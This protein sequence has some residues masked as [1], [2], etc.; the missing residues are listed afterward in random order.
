MSRKFMFRATLLTALLALTI[1]PV[2]LAGKGGGKPGG[3]G[4]TGGT[5]SLSLVLLDS[6]D[7]LAHYG[8][9]VTFTASTT[10][11]DR[12]FVRLDCYQGSTWVSTAS[13]G[14][15]AD[16]PWDKF[17]ILRST[18][19]TGGAADCTATMYKTTDGSR[20]TNLATYRFH[21]YA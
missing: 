16:Y 14:L 8:Q 11:T 10:A 15:F 9:R 6:T 7:G 19:W 2:A 17:F 18:G 21:V 20:L 12:P 5:G 13:I 1:A 3:G 4:T